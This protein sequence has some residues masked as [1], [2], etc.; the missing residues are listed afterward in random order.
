MFFSGTIGEEAAVRALQQGASDYVLKHT[1][2]RLPSAVARAIREARTEREREHAEKELMRSQRLDCLAM[3]AAGL[4]H[5]LRNIL[6]PLLIVPDL[7]AQRSEDPRLHQLA[8]VVAECGR[9]GHEEVETVVAR[10]DLG[11]NVRDRA[12]QERRTGRWQ[13]NLGETPEGRLRAFA[14][15]AEHRPGVALVDRQAAVRRHGKGTGRQE[16]VA[17]HRRADKQELVGRH[18][19]GNDLRRH[20]KRI[21]GRRRAVTGNDR[22]LARR[23]AGRPA[24]RHR[25]SVRRAWRP[26]D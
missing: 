15:Q 19:T 1:P 20:G 24:A 25:A 22:G 18:A 11:R 23:D 10:D 21:E 8:K 6:Q 5:D 14:E 7:I 9:R 12:L 17:E 26:P 13:R 4:S 16:L 3:L 2:A